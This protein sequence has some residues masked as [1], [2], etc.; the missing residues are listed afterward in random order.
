LERADVLVVGGGPAGATAAFQVAR[1]GLDVM[2]VDRARFPRDKTCGESV[3]PGGI[4]RLESIGLSLRTL[5]SSSAMVPAFPI[6]GMRIHSPAATSFQGRYRNPENTSGAVLRRLDLDAALL[7]AAKERGTRV[8]EGVEVLGVTESSLEGG[9]VRAR[10][11]GTSSEVRIAA[12]RIIV[13]DGRSSFLARQLGFLE[14]AE[15]R[16]PRFAVRAHC[17][18]IEGLGDLA[19]MHVGSRGYC[20]IAPLSGSAANVCFVVFGRT[21]A[22][23]PDAMASGFRRHVLSFPGIAPRFQTARVVSPVRAIGPLRLRSRAVSSGAFVACGDTTGFLDP[24]TG[25]GITHA[26]ASGAACAEAVADSVRGDMSAF[27]GYKR[28]LV[29]MRGSKPAAAK[30]LFTLITR[31]ALANGTARLLA[32]APRLAD[33]LVRFFGDQV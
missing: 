23:K 1:A 33:A 17:D 14:P 22:L 7:R 15:T 5:S 4:R 16:S 13:A 26:I 31:P 3:S 19:E 10:V 8:L 28:R 32:R 11:V 30:L 2:L 18:G 27:A 20:G 21:V 9:E 25:E 12:R 6:R 24:F 29:E